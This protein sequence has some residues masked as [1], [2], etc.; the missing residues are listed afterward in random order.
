[1]NQA[2]MRRS[3][4]V[5]DIPALMTVLLMFT[6]VRGLAGKGGAKFSPLAVLW[7]LHMSLS[8]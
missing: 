6:L 4:G 5:F 1:M 2:V 3:G 8:R 7:W